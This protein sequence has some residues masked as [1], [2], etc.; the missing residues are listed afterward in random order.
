[1]PSRYRTGSL[2]RMSLAARLTF[3]R[4]EHYWNLTTRRIV[5]RMAEDVGLID[6]LIDWSHVTHMKKHME[7]AGVLISDYPPHFPTDAYVWKIQP[8][9]LLG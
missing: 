8:N 6:V 4:L 7:R 2:K 3:V 5:N 1:M 9:V